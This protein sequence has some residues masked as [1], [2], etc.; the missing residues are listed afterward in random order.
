MM[1]GAEKEAFSRDV[2][3]REQSISMHVFDDA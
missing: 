3:M 1:D 2:I